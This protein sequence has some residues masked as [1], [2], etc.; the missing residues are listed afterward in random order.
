MGVTIARAAPADAAAILE[1]L[2]QIGGE[3]DNLSFGAEGLPFTPEEEAAYI[4]ERTD[5]RDG[6]LLLA[7]AED[8]AIL[9]D[10]S[11]E[12]GARRMNHRGEFGISVVRSRWGEGIGTQLMERVIDFAKENG[13]EIIDLEVRSDNGRAIRLYRKFGFRTLCTYPGFCKIG[14]NPVD[15]DLMVLRLNEAD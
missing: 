2:K 13:F 15:Y 14:D 10:A 7:K 11:L 8:G 4:A 9:G 12:R 3:T 5:S 1:Y 6:I